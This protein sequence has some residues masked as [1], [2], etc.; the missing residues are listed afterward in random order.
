[1]STVRLRIVDA[2][3]A[4]IAAATG[5]TPYRNL[6]YALEANNLPAV[7]LRAGHEG[8]SAGE[9]SATTTEAEVEIHVLVSNSANPEA[10]ADPIDALIHRALFAD[11]RFGGLARELNRVSAGWDFDLG[12]CCQRSL[13]Y[14]VA[15]STKVNDL[16]LS[17]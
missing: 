13:V 7:V 8:A 11:F 10:S 2:M 4:A 1:M 14:R 9:I 12:D 15:Y 6:D 5:L 3:A 17:S 16:E